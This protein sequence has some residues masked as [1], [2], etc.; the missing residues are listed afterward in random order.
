MIKYRMTRRE[1]TELLAEHENSQR[2]K[3]LG[4]KLK[5]GLRPFRMPVDAAGNKISNAAIRRTL[6]KEAR[7]ESR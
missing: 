6:K 2:S 5:T 1:Y 3:R 7:E 4:P